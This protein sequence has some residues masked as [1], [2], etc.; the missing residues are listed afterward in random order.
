METFSSNPAVKGGLDHDVFIFICA[1]RRSSGVH[2]G[3]DEF[4]AAFESIRRLLNRFKPQLKH[5]IKLNKSGCL[6]KC[7]SGPNLVI[8]PDNIWY[9]FTSLSDLEEVIMSHALN[10]VPVQRLLQVPL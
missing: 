4:D 3:S 6:G 7:G 9:R 1:N 2:C 8:F 5:K 10:G